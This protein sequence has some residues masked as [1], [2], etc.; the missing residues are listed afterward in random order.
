M[1]SQLT[2]RGINKKLQKYLDYY[3]NERLHLGLQCNTPWGWLQ[4]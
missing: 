1:S 2:L 3:N 4:R